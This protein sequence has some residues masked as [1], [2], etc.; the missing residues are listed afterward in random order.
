MRFPTW[1]PWRAAVAA[2]AEPLAEPD[3]RPVEA[4]PDVPVPTVTASMTLPLA[5]PSGTDLANAAASGWAVY[6]HGLTGALVRGRQEPA[7]GW[8]T[9][10]HEG[11]A[12][13]RTRYQAGDYILKP[14]GN[15]PRRAV[16]QAEFEAQFAP[17]EA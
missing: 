15:A 3:I 2:E 11:G 10:H 12:D 8:I 16:A 17:A 7:G 5:A 6:R 1:W 14:F 4:E 13:E 9:V